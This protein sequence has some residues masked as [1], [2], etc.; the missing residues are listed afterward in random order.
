MQ[1]AGSTSSFA[2]AY[3]FALAGMPSVLPAASRA[4]APPGL[5]APGLDA[6]LDTSPRAFPDFRR[7]SRLCF[8]WRL[9]SLKGSYSD[10]FTL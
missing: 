2:A 1:I 5:F 6:K 10:G 4:S 9:R 7:G 8:A 3:F